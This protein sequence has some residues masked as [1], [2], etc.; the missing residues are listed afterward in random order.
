MHLGIEIEADYLLNVI[1]DAR[2]Y[3]FNKIRQQLL[4]KNHLSSNFCDMWQLLMIKYSL[5]RHR[6]F[7]YTVFFNQ[8]LCSENKPRPISQKYSK[9]SQENAIEN[10]LF[11]HERMIITSYEIVYHLP[12]EVHN[13]F[14][15]RT[16]L[17]SIY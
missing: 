3:F 9:I 15:I 1:T 13:F 2:E 8:W 14:W 10:K 4:T 11:Q 6:A 17:D 5:F 12:R 7:V 16:S